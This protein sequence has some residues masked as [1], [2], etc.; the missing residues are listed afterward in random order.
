MV[1]HP[2]LSVIVRQPQATTSANGMTVEIHNDQLKFLKNDR[3]W[4]VVTSTNTLISFAIRP[5]PGSGKMFD[6]ITSRRM[7]S[8]WSRTTPS[9]ISTFRIFA[10][11]RAE[12]R[13]AG[14]RSGERIPAAA[15]ACRGK[16]PSR[17]VGAG[18][19]TQPRQW[20]AGIAAQ[21]SN[22]RAA[23]RA[24]CRGA[25]SNAAWRRL[26]FP[27]SRAPADN[28]LFPARLARRSVHTNGRTAWNAESQA[29]L[30]DVLIDEKFRKSIPLDQASDFVEW[31]A[32]I[33]ERVSLAANGVAWRDPKGDKFLDRRN[34][35]P[36]VVASASGG[37]NNPSYAVDSATRG[38][39]LARQHFDIRTLSPAH[40]SG[41]VWSGEGEGDRVGT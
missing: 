40:W 13:G 24:S 26:H 12:I 38:T 33:S 2:S 32:G 3:W 17:T 29:E 27:V 10:C 20:R 25:L 36:C 9:L 35:Y 22:K 21:R 5:N 11:A 6:H 19:A 28:G 16:F 37:Q 34:S 8:L 14:C 41:S 31:C 7:A 15:I 4:R 1:G 39:S 30:F 18:D 23:D